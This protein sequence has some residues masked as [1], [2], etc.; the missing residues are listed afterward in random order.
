MSAWRCKNEKCLKVFYIAARKMVKT[1][2]EPPFQT[3]T[4]IEISCC[5]FCYSVS[6]EP[7]VCIKVNKL[8]S[9]TY[10]LMFDTYLPIRWF[11]VEDDKFDGIEVDVDKV[12]KRDQKLINELLEALR[13]ADISL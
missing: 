4:T 7:C 9:D 8:S 5:P 12:S 1:P 13:K 3:G 2:A 10:P 6:F 11:F